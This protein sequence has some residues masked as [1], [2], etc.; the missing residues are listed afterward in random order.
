LKNQVKATMVAARNQPI[1][2]KLLW[3]D[4]DVNADGLEDGFLGV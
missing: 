3:A 1:G 4:L 2:C